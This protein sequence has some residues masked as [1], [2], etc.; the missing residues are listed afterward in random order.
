MPEAFITNPT[1]TGGTFPG[2]GSITDLP[3]AQ[4]TYGRYGAINACEGAARP[5]FDPRT[6]TP[7]SFSHCEHRAQKFSSKTGVEWLHEASGCGHDPGRVIRSAGKCAARRFPRRILRFSR[8]LFRVAW[9]LRNRRRYQPRRIP[10][11]GPGQSCRT[12]ARPV[13]RSAFQPIRGT[14]SGPIRAPALH[15]EPHAVW[16]P[17]PPVIRAANGNTSPAEHG[18]LSRPDALRWQ[19]PP[20]RR[21]RPPTP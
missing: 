9:V 8:R 13:F 4:Q 10:R 7:P 1:N 11:I 18:F 16:R 14:S 12:S 3:T 19:P 17:C 20:R 15:F 2:W 5:F 6:T 21:G